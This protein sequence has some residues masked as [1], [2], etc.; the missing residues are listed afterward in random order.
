MPR[1]FPIQIAQQFGAR[2]YDHLK[3]TVAASYTLSLA[4]G[5]VFTVVMQL[6]ARPGLVLLNTP[7]NIIGDSLSYL[8][9]S[10]S[11]FIVVMAYNMF[12]SVL[13]AL[14]DSKTPLIA[15]VIA[16]AINIVLDI[17]FVMGLHMGVAQRRCGD[18]DR[19]VAFSAVYCFMAV[20]KIKLLKLSAR[21]WR[22]KRP[23]YGKAYVF[24]ER[25][26]LSKM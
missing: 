3:K 14:G 20:R 4:M 11:G 7:E 24:G 2:D 1:D 13:R 8:R 5:V 22:P 15:M 12:A 21:D 6:A 18:C 9:V 23:P 19:S 17:A 25:P 10:F 16:A 26:W